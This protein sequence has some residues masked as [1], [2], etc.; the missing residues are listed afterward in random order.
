MSLMH[1]REGDMLDTT[2]GNVVQTAPAT[3]KRALAMVVSKLPLYRG[4]WEGHK[5]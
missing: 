2:S 3:D 1:T 4:G 5:L